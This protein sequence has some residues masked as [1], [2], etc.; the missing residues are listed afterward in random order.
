MAG[1]GG[2]TLIFSYIRRLRKFWG[3][4]NFKFQCFW[5]SEKLIILM[6]EDFVDIWGGHRKIGLV[7]GVISMH[8]RVFKVQN[9][10]IYFLGGAGGGVRKFQI[11]FWGVLILL[12]YF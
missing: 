10:D 7:L 11:L 12:L 8:F 4:Q 1:V 3:V 9:G 2:G 5:G 6:Y